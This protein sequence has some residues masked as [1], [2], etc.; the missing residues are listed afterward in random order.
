[1]KAPIRTR[2]Q[3]FMTEGQQLAGGIEASEASDVRH[4]F[5]SRPVNGY[6]FFFEDK[7]FDTGAGFV[8]ELGGYIVP[9]GYNLFLRSVEV[10]GYPAAGDNDNGVLTIFGPSTVTLADVVQMQ[11]LIDG[12]S[13]PM[14]TS[15][16]SFVNAQTLVVPLNGIPL[17][18]FGFSTK[19]IPCFILVPGGSRISAAFFSSAIAGMTPWNV[20]VDYYGN[21]ISDTG[22]SIANEVGNDTPLPV[23]MSQG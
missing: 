14:W 12:V 5:D 15:T 3:S 7:F 11:I 8:P 17:P 16:N 13:T 2:R 21:L 23:I 22:R 9:D 10:T 20:I 19:H 18:D 4:V 6:D 1:M